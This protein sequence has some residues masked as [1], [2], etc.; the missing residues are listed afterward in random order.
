MYT[1]TNY[2]V[3]PKVGEANIAIKGNR[4]K[5]YGDKSKRIVYLKDN[6]EF[7]IELFNPKEV[8]VLAKIKLN[9][10]YISNGG[11]V[12][13]PAQRVFLKRY[14]DVDQKFLFSTYEVEDT[15]ASKE[16][17]K[18]NGNLIVEFYD[19]VIPVQNN[20][21]YG[22]TLTLGNTPINTGSFNFGSSNIGIGTTNIGSIRSKSG[23]PTLSTFTCSSSNLDH[24]SFSDNNSKSFETG[25][26]EKGEAS[27]QKL[28]TVNNDFSI[29]YSSYLE[30][31]L[32]PESTKP[33]EAKDIRNYCTNCGT[34]AKKS[35]WV[36]CPSCGNK[37]N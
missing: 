18:N 5:E 15:K 34:K 1:T 21:Y 29:F 32:L 8:T 35:S 22:N 23:T 37:F 28:K 30:I 6:T 13:K 16:A 17:I 10:Q 25:R 19:E 20:Y 12:L 36:F 26:V 7:E 33:V 11:I 31:S 24:L 2:I 9:G 27:D 4:I 3:N 14:L